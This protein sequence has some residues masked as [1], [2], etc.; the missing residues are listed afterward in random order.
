MEK[1]FKT[2][3]RVIYR[4]ADSLGVWLLLVAILFAARGYF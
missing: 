3:F 4:V 2:L 1:H